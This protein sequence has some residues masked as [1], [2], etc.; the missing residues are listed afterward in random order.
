[1]KEACRKHEQTHVVSVCSQLSGATRI[2]V[3]LYGQILHSLSPML[4]AIKVNMVG[5]SFPRS[6][7]S[8][9]IKC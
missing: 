6:T 4:L 3:T 2:A 5:R 9:V 7:N 8:S 1:V